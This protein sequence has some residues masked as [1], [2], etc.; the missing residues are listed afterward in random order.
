MRHFKNNALNKEMRKRFADGTKTLGARLLV[1]NKAEAMA[2]DLNSVERVQYLIPYLAKHLTG[3]ACQ[4]GAM[5]IDDLVQESHIAVLRAHETHEP[6]VA[7]WTTYAGFCIKRQL[8]RSLADQAFRVRVPNDVAQLVCKYKRIADQRCEDNWLDPVVFKAISGQLGI[9]KAQKDRLWFGLVSLSSALGAKRADD[10]RKVYHD[11]EIADELS[12][13]NT[14]EADLVRKEE[15][16]MLHAALEKMPDAS[17]REL[18]MRRYGI[19]KHKETAMSEIAKE[20]GVTR[21]AMRQRFNRALAQL[22]EVMNIPE[23]EEE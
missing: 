20:R 19:G 18:L 6:S 2:A 8:T 13:E 10:T 22:K 17:Y 4:H 5:D 7:M 15:A 23:E 14:L 21:E 16:A 12:E 11:T 1:K 9:S 3:V